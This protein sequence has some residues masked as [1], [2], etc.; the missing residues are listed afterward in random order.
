MENIPRFFYEIQI[1][2]TNGIIV[3]TPENYFIVQDIKKLVVIYKLIAIE[4]Q[5]QIEAYIPYYI[6]DGHT[7]KL[8]ANML[9]PFFCFNDLNGICPNTKDG[10]HRG[11]LYKL[12]TTENLNLKAMNDYINKELV[13]K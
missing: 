10:G 7:N 12:S 4:D 13:Y 2:T 11:L 8:R 5:Q 6:S 1:P 3:L 9:Y